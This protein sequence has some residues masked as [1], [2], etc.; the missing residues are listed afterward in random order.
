MGAPVKRRPSPS[1]RFAF[2][3]LNHG[4]TANSDIF[5][6]LHHFN[7]QNMKILWEFFLLLPFFPSSVRQSCS[8]VALE[9]KGDDVYA[10]I[11]NS[12]KVSNHRTPRHYD[13][14]GLNMINN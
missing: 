4:L 14:Y 6:S 9:R 3:Q 12:S 1:D 13:I 8:A 10:T 2:L 5:L 7:T 11:E